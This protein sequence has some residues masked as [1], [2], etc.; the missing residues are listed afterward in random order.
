MKKIIAASIATLLF[1]T[2]CEKH[3]VDA[4]NAVDTNTANA[5][6]SN[7]SEDANTSNDDLANADATNDTDA[8]NDGLANTADDTNATETK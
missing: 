5:D 1:L 2:A 7:P 6:A 8:T 3:P 4:G